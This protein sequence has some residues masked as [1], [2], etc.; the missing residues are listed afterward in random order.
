[1]SIPILE[2]AASHRPGDAA[3]AAASE[4][5]PDARR[6]RAAARHRSS[7]TSRRGASRS[8]RRSCSTSCAIE[9]D[10]VVAGAGID[11]MY[12]DYVGI[13]VNNEVWS[14]HLASVPFERRLLLLPKCLRVEDKCPAP[15]DEF[16]L[17]CKQC[18]LCTIQDLQE[19]AER[20]GYAVLVAE[21]FGA[22]HGADSVRKDR[23]HRRRQLP[24]G[25]RTCVPVHGGRGRSGRGDSAPAGR[26]QGHGRRH[27]LGLE[28]RP[29]HERR[30]HPTARS[31]RA[32]HGSGDVVHARRARRRA[33]PG[34]RRSGSR[35][36]SAGSAP[37]ANGGGRS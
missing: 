4:H 32:P 35:R 34:G 24:V 10:A 2:K 36:Q 25:A 9:A 1:M 23:R 30:P 27:R 33:R 7:A 37:R 16:G 14:E 11:P 22:R 18:G 6:A 5:P 19:E 31:R 8:C 21:G 29:P 26:L 17:L 20:L 15:F 3:E 28:R 12:R 13:L